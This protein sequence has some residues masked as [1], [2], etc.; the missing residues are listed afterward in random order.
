RVPV[1]ALLDARGLHDGDVGLAEEEVREDQRVG[2][3]FHDAAARDLGAV[4]A[5]QRGH[6]ALHGRARRVAEPL[7][8]PLVARRPVDLEVAVAPVAHH[9]FDRLLSPT[10]RWYCDCG[11]VLKSERWTKPRW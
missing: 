1:H 8:R 7:E 5:I 2:G 3:A 6:E 4:A 11:T 9:G 10:T